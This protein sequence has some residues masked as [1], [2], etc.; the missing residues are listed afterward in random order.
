MAA[1][2]PAASD[3][4][5]PKRLS[6]PKPPAPPAPPNCFGRQFLIGALHLAPSAASSGVSTPL[7]DCALANLSAMPLRRPR[8]P[9][10]ARTMPK[11]SLPAVAEPRLKMPQPA[12]S[13][14]A[15]L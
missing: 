15:P 6:A 5:A 12:C 7:I 4:P 14:R 13:S 9:L 3:R 10:L 8:S 1:E 11:E 2:L